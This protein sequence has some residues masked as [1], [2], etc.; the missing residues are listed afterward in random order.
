MRGPKQRSLHICAA[1][2]VQLFKP[3]HCGDTAITDKTGGCKDEAC[4]GKRTSAYEPARV[5]RVDEETGDTVLLSNQA[6]Q[7]VCERVVY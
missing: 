4:D 7:F 5:T 2:A 1:L 3:A 6:C